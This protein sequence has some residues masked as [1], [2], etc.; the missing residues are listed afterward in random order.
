MGGNDLPSLDAVRA[1]LVP[2]KLTEEEFQQ[3]LEQ[4][5]QRFPNSPDS[6]LA[7]RL[8]SL[9]GIPPALNRRGRTR[10]NVKCIT[11][12][13][14]GDY[15]VIEVFLFN[16]RSAERE[17][18][19]KYDVYTAVDGDYCTFP[20]FDWE[21]RLSLDGEFVALKL[22][23]VLC[24]V[25]RD[26][27]K[28]LSF[29]SYSRCEAVN[30]VFLKPPI[31]EI[32]QI[33]DGELVRCRGEA[34]YGSLR[35]SG[36]GTIRLRFHDN[37]RWLFLIFYPDTVDRLRKT[38]LNGVDYS[39]LDKYA[40]EVLGIYVEKETPTKKGISAKRFVEKNFIKV[41]DIKLL[42]KIWEE[43]IEQEEAGRESEKVSDKPE[44]K[45]EKEEA[46]PP[47]VEELKAEEIHEV[48]ET[49]FSLSPEWEEDELVNILERKVG[50]EDQARAIIDKAIEHGL[51]EVASGAYR[52]R[53]VGEN[54]KQESQAVSGES[55]EEDREVV[56]GYTLNIIK[57]YEVIYGDGVTEDELFDEVRKKKDI[58]REEFVELLKMLEEQGR[59]HKFEGKYRR[60]V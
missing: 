44:E 3:K 1:V 23:D 18:G 58:S 19:T 49:V 9:Y 21:R 47:A 38:S 54:Q 50:S 59:I 41:V 33:S 39:D 29:G 56:I 15:G 45:E 10:R 51:L 36:K 46:A 2:S 55:G 53:A 17:D 32:S 43:D 4:L 25:G 16:K 13:E 12:L 40:M 34:L 52:L 27:R 35:V 8:A 42:E 7:T 48:L 26:G 6:A 28:S 30:Q 24:R 20:V 11:E 57:E 22:Y 5:R 37:K 14:P 31:K 60:L